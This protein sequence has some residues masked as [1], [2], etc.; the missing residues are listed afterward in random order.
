MQPLTPE[1]AQRLLEV[2]SG[3]KLEALL[4]VA[5]ATGMRRGELFGLHWQDVDFTEEC[6][7]VRRSVRRLGKFGVVVSEPKTKGSKR[8]I[9]LP[10]FVIDVLKQHQQRLQALRDKA[11]SEWREKDIVFCNQFGDYLEASWLNRSFKQL[12]QRA[13]LPN[14]RFHDL[15]HSTASFLAKLNVH[16]KIVQEML[17]HSTISM[18]LDIYSH[19]FP[20]SHQEAVTKLSDLFKKET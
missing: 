16:P 15:R 11:G 12:L 19:M 14:I 5:L 4:T 7:Y 8:K 1:Q 17:G 9:M 10:S 13:K 2:A 3:H 18:T 6:L 20:F